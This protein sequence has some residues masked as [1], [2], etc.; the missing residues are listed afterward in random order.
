MHQ[1]MGVINDE[2]AVGDRVAQ[3]D[4]ALAIPGANDGVRALQRRHELLGL[5]G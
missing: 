5:L 2:R 3:T 4:Q 1:E